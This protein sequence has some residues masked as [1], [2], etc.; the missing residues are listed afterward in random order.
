LLSAEKN[1]ND[2]AYIDFFFT[3]WQGSKANQAWI[4]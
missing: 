3:D 2:I 1:M 4:P